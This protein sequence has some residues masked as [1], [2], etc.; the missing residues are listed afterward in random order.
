MVHRKRG[1][2]QFYPTGKCTMV[3]INFTHMPIKWN[4]LETL[5]VDELATLMTSDYM[6]KD[7]SEGQP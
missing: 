1:Q 7:L 5:P 4:M 2:D 3:D 6:E